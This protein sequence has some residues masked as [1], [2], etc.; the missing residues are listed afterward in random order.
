MEQLAKANY[1][2]MFWEKAYDRSKEE[3]KKKDIEIRRL[4]EIIRGS[5]NSTIHS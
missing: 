3:N 1:E 5:A 4:N 2:K